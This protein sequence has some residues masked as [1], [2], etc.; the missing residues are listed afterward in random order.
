M[1]A[2]W[3]KVGGIL[4]KGHQVASGMAE[5]SPYPRGTIAMQTSL[6]KKLGVDLCGYFPGTLNISIAPYTFK[7]ENPEYTFRQVKWLKEYPS[8]DFS[9][10]R[11]R[12][13][14]QNT[15]CDGWIYYPHPETK[16]G[17]FQDDSTIEIIAP[18]IEDL[19]YGDRLEVE[20]N[21]NELVI[22]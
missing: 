7:V 6:F 14:Y 16:I 21:T 22:F 4:R 15:V 9:F 1:D 3:L 19:N 5:D 17:H 10:S 12:I 20:I 11:C 2:K 13:I 8:E 18:K